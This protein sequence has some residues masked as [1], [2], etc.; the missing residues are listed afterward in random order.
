LKPARKVLKKRR[1]PR[2]RGRMGS[3]LTDA[4]RGLV[5]VGSGRPRAAATGFATAFR[6]LVRI[7]AND[8]GGDGTLH[9]SLLLDLLHVPHEPVPGGLRARTS[10]PVS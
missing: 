7:C 6:P 2:E 1:S 4:P 5:A 10:P 8:D 3:S 9:A